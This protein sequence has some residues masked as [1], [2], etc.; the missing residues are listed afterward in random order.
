MLE[1]ARSS[2]RQIRGHPGF[3]GAVI[4]TLA[5]SVGATTAVFTLADPMLFRPLPYPEPDRLVRISASGGEGR[6]GGRVLLA[7]F[8][9]LAANHPGFEAVA[10][11]GMA[12]VGRIEGL[13]ATVLAYDVSP[14]F[15]DLLRVRPVVGRAFLPGEHLTGAQSPEVALITHALW[16][17]A[18]GGDPAVVGQSIE[19]AGLRTAA[20]ASSACCPGTSS[21]RTT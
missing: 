16:Q 17:A 3:A 11:F 5:L 1:A 15:F 4:V 19:L 2:L 12:A 14:G 8:E 9:R 18:F 6:Y 20:A 10:E 7:D 21:F 13:D